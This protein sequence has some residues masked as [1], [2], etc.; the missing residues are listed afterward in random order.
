MTADEMRR[1]AEFL[2]GMACFVADKEVYRLAVR[3]RADA[4][5]LAAQ[6]APSAWQPIETAPRDC[7][8]LLLDEPGG[9]IANGNW[10]HEAYGGNGAWI[11]PHKHRKP[12]YWMPLP[13]APKP[14]GGGEMHT[15][16]PVTAHPSR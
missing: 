14:E 7:E 15:Y 16:R 4:D 1:A 6:P 9:S 13:P 10:L 11:W 3:L 12:N 2:D 8:V 5:Y